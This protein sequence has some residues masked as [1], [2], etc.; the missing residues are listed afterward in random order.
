L[1]CCNLCRGVCWHK[2][3]RSIQ[4]DRRPGVHFAAFVVRVTPDFRRQQNCGRDHASAERGNGNRASKLQQ[5]DSSGRTQP[6]RRRRRR[7]NALHGSGGSKQQYD[8]VQRRRHAPERHR[9]LNTWKLDFRDTD[10]DLVGIYYNTCM[11]TPKNDRNYGID[12]LRGVAVLMVLLFHAAQYPGQSEAYHNLIATGG[13]GVDLFFVLSGFL[14]SGLLLDEGKAYGN[15]WLGRFWMRRGLKIWPS[16]YIAYGS[17]FIGL[18]IMQ[19]ERGSYALHALPNFLFVQNYFSPEYRW[20]ASWSLAIE[21]HFY[22][23]LPILM[24]L[25]LLT[26]NGLKWLPVACVA[27]CITCPVL[28]WFGTNSQAVF[29][30]THY[31]VD[32]LAYGVLMGYLLRHCP[33]EFAK[34]AELWPVGLALAVVTL[35][36]TVAYP[37]HESAWTRSVGL[38][39]LAVSFAV[40][41]AAATVSQLG[42]N[43]GQPVRGVARLLNWCGQYSYT[44]YVFQ[45]VCF[46]FLRREGILARKLGAWTGH[47]D[48]MHGFVFFTAAIFGGVVVSHL[49]ERPF[50]K[51][52]DKY[53]PSRKKVGLPI[54]DETPSSGDSK[55][56]KNIV[57]I[58]PASETAK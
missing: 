5:F 30:Q 58:A 9:T 41:I 16:Y 46:S 1:R 57:N 14:I 8:L 12:V 37:F 39:A 20:P 56:F 31:R 3:H 29:A 48:L 22:L 52:R 6:L 33:L 11:N 23:A 51:L 26:R 17:V 34:I 50:L 55:S 35:G 21:E 18:L 38:S 43:A 45:V 19:S 15:L 25:F 36:L 24:S 27:V 32:G 2:R 40:L 42:K 7:G 10:A 4:Q 49:V 47:R 44:I 54:P 28:R 53:W 13:Y